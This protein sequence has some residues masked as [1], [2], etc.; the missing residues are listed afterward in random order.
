[1]ASVGVVP[2]S[3]AQQQVESAK[4]WGIGV[5]WHFTRAV[6]VAV[7]YE[8]TTFSGGASTGNRKPEAAVITRFQTSF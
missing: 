3:V 4:A 5:N 7:G 6:K 2:Q 8:R 1:V